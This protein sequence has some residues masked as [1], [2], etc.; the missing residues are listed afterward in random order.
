M[1]LSKKVFG[2]NV[3]PEIIE[4]FKALQEGRLDIQPNEVVTSKIPHEKYLGDRTPYVRMWTAVNIRETLSETGEPSKVSDSYNKIFTINDNRESSY[5]PLD[6]VENDNNIRVGEFTYGNPYLKPVAGITSVSSKSEGSLG[7]LRRTNVDFMVHNKADFEKIFLPFFLKPGVTVFVD[8]GWSDKHLSLYDPVEYI[9][10][11]DLLMT[12][13]YGQIYTRTTDEIDK[14]FMTTLSGQVTKCDVNVDDKGS[15]KCNLEFVSSN[16]ALLDRTVDDDNN[17]RFIFSNIIE[18]LLLGYFAKASDIDVG[19]MIDYETIN[20][21]PAE[22]R[23][24]LVKDFFDSTENYV[25]TGK[26][27]D[28]AKK[29]GMFYQNLSKVGGDDD[30]EDKE[31]L[32]ISYGLFEDK[33][34]NSFISYWVQVDDDGNEI[35]SSEKKDYQIKFQSQNSYIR[36]D[37]DLYALQMLDL[38]G[39]EELLPFL[40]PDTWEIDETYNGENKPVIE[41]DGDWTSTDDDKSKRRIPLRELFISV[42]TIAEAFKRAT[43]VN[44]ALEAIFDKIYDESGTIINIKMSKNNDAETSISFIDVNVALEAPVDND[45]LL[46]FDV[47][48]GN[49]VVLNS[50]FKIETPKAGLASMISIANSSFSKVYHDLEKMKFNFLNAVQGNAKQSLVSLPT[51]GEMRKSQVIKIDFA[52]LSEQNEPIVGKDFYED[53]TSESPDEEDSGKVIAQK[54]WNSYKKARTEKLKE[55]KKDSK[56]D[57]P[58]APANTKEKEL[59]D[60]TSDGKQILYATSDRDYRLLLAKVRNFI[61]SDSK[62]ISPVLPV[63]LELVVYGNNFLG[64]GDFFTINFLPEHFKERIFFQIMGVSHSVDNSMWKTTYT[65][66]MRLRNQMKRYS[67][68]THKDISVIVKYHPTVMKTKSRSF[69]SSENKA[70]NNAL[71]H[72]VT[73]VKYESTTRVNIYDKGKASVTGLTKNDLPVT[74]H[75]KYTAT[76]DMKEEL[77]PELNIKDADKVKIPFF[78][79]ISSVSQWDAKALG[80]AVAVSNILLNDKYI[81]YEQ[82]KKDTGLELV[83]NRIISSKISRNDIKKVWVSPRKLDAG[84]WGGIYTKIIDSFDNPNSWDVGWDETQKA[85]DEYINNISRK[86]NTDHIETDPSGSDNFTGF[87]FFK[88]LYWKLT[89]EVTDFWVI[90]TKGDRAMVEILPTIVIPKKYLVVPVDKLI[91][92]IYSRTMIY[93][94]SIKQIIERNIKK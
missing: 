94:M 73:D 34:L 18:E 83:Y 31:S 82:Y 85:I 71:E 54:R 57:T 37:A 66:A 80:H 9:E 45:G 25:T 46:E 1:D 58:P 61:T 50:D 60:E 93:T 36:Y 16:Y 22:E 81:N 26:I 17:L 43:N 44:D 3:K 56:D 38:M 4:Y 27:G 2:S 51:R 88:G 20:K 52:K 29:L 75:A 68:A 42:P 67:N 33:F 5:D 15:F 19:N 59:P 39:D 74:T 40:Y 35:V 70:D 90:E 87:Y 76:V 79:N 92:D 53:E 62:S 65:T 91:D 13:F 23:S 72:M 8:F 78:S 41:D 11:S 63:T 12:N 10:D 84:G 28:T 48:S 47:T 86:G 69:F 24:S 55:L 64:F 21:L 14:G 6:T 32:Y 7:A 30:I 49:T 77:P 89:D